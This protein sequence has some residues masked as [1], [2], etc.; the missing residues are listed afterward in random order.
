[1][2]DAELKKHVQQAEERGL[3]RLQMPPV[4]KKRTE[5]HSVISKDPALQGHDT[6]KYVFTDI[7]YPANDYQRLIVV[8][9]TDGTLR[10]ATWDERHRFNQIYYPIKGRELRHP[11]MFQ[12][13]YLKV[14]FFTIAQF[15]ACGQTALY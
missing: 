15:H 10:H 12:D 2:T 13:P 11:R 3:K 4:V 9:E 6:A 1:M 5:I 7:T 8:R 14:N